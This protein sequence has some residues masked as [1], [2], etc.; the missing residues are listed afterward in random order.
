MDVRASRLR[1]LAFYDAIGYPPTAVELALASAPGLVEPPMREHRG[2]IT[3]EGREALVA[4]HERREALFPRKIRKARRV[5]R[6]LSRLPGVRFVALCNT[7]ALANARDDGD[8]DF[9]VVTRRGSLALAR[10]LAT[11]WYALTGSRPGVRNTDRDAVCLS[12]WVDD[13][14][15]DLSSLMLHGDDPYFRFWFLSLLPLYDD[16]VSVNLWEA[17]AAIRAKHPHARVWI[18]SP[19][20]R[21]KKTFPRFPRL[22]FLDPIVRR[23]QEYTFSSTLKSMRNTDTRVVITPHVL[24]FHA[25][26]GR[27]AFRERYRVTCKRY[28]LDS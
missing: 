5:A 27:A 15:L 16:G 18:P 26:D 6:F 14:A 8:L 4:E 22:A 19:D 21:V 3:F 17:N 10:A 23:L 24:K 2:R 12:F 20:L 13:S 9:F 25:E 1:A 7:T 11:T 28:G